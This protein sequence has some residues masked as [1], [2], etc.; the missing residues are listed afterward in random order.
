MTIYHSLHT[1]KTQCLYPDKRY[2]HKQAISES[3]NLLSLCRAL[4]YPI[5]LRINDYA[6]SEFLDKFSRYC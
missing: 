3:R 6:R 2:A 5:Q 4:F 1:T